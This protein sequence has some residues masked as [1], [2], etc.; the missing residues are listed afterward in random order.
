MNFEKRTER[1][2]PYTTLFDPWISTTRVIKTERK[3]EIIQ[4]H[5]AT[6]FISV[7]LSWYDQRISSD[8][9]YFVEKSFSII[10]FNTANRFV[11]NEFFLFI[12]FGENSIPFTVWIQT[13]VKSCSRYFFSFSVLRCVLFTFAPSSSSIQRNSAS[14]RFSFCFRS[15]SLRFGENSWN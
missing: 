4:K 8:D 1:D 5:S 7:C 15:Q 3:R 12:Q 10:C 2:R 9:V 13:S 14:N 6:P 11:S